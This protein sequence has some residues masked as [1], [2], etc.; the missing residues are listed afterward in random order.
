MAASRAARSRASSEQVQAAILATTVEI[1]LAK[2]YDRTSTDEIAA[3]ASVSKQTL[4]KYY[5]DKDAL[6]GAAIQSL[7]SAAERQGADALDALAASDDL[8]RDLRLFAR[9]HIADVI[10]PE[11]MQMR[12]RLIGAADR[13]P[14]LARAWYRAAPQRGHEML[15]RILE[16]LRE[17]GLLT[18]KDPLI[19]A[20]HLNWLI[21]SIPLNRAMFDI[22]APASREE[23][24][25]YADAAI[26]AFLGAYGARRSKNRQMGTRG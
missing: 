22:D 3:G 4:Y 16:R 5:R 26:D 10:Q 21:L 13:F 9:Q 7:I 19:A 25:H 11:I 14:E 24:D 18:F 1:F 23:Y 2:G 12:R 8:E 17:R 15:A 6:I 20:E